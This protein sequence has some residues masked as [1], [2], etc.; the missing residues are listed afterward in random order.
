M[1]DK[2]ADNQEALDTAQ[3]DPLIHLHSRETISAS[4]RSWLAVTEMETT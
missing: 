2:Q 1:C 4:A 3:N